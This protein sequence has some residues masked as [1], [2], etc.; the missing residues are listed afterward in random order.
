M[1]YSLKDELKA[2]L[3]KIRKNV[4][5]EMYNK[6]LTHTFRHSFLQL[7]CGLIYQSFI[8]SNII[9]LNYNLCIAFIQIK[10]KS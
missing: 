8:K 4:Q 3:I 7:Y 2:F 10:I 6:F 1:V 5:K 9:T